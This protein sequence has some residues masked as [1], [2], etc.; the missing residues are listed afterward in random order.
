MAVLVAQAVPGN[1]FRRCF[2]LRRFGN[3]QGQFFVNRLRPCAEVHFLG[4]MPQNAPGVHV[5]QDPAA[6]HFGHRQARLI[7]NPVQALVDGSPGHFRPGHIRQGLPQGRGAVNFQHL[8][9]QQKSCVMF[10]IKSRRHPDGI[11][12]V[13][14][15][16]L[17]R[18]QQRRRAHIVVKIAV[19]LKNHALAGKL[20]LEFVHVPL[21]FIIKSRRR[22]NSAHRAM[23]FCVI[24]SCSFL[25]P[26]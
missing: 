20:R 15:H 26:P 11:A 14:A 21:S 18:V 6:V 16:L 12:V 13:R 5:H 25:N 8:L 3:G 9:G 1:L 4:H 19:F 23:V 24:R 7:L 22:P 10:F 2:H 17:H